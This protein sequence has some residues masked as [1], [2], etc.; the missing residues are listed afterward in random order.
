M[1]IRARRN[2]NV[3]NLSTFEHR[4]RALWWHGVESSY[5]LVHKREK[6]SNDIWI[7]KEFLKIIKCS[8]FTRH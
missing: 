4:S 6:T 8:I 7:N 3:A 5:R 2:A 1:V